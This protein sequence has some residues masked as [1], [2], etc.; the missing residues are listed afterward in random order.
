MGSGI[1]YVLGIDGLPLGTAAV[2][3]VG[4]SIQ[5]SF[6]LTAGLV[7]AGMNERV[8]AAVTQ[9][10]ADL[11]RLPAEVRLFCI[12]DGEAGGE[13]I[14]A[15]EWLAARNVGFLVVDPMGPGGAQ[16]L[17]APSD[18]ILQTRSLARARQA[19]LG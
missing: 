14:Q 17:S 1:P 6:H 18:E 8:Q 2:A 16:L 7:G 10:D 5:L 15:G 9:A 3:A 4:G 19:A 13:L 12:D 11:G